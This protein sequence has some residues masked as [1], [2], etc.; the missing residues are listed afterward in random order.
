MSLFQVWAAR[1]QETSYN[2]Y[3]WD[4][5]GVTPLSSLEDII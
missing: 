2:M 3:F 1:E 4:F 5:V